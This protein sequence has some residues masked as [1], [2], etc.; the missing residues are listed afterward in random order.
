M[1]D[2]KAVFKAVVREATVRMAESP[3][4]F[5]WKSPCIVPCLYLAWVKWNEI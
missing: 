3:A 2:R 4:R 1:K 5:Y